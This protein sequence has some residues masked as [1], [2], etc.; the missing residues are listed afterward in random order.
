MPDIDVDQV[1]AK[2]RPFWDAAVG[3]DLKLKI[4][5]VLY[6][7][8]QPDSA[9]LTL[10]TTGNPAEQQAALA[11]LFPNPGPQLTDPLKVTAIVT[12]IFTAFGEAAKKK[13]QASRETMA[14]AVMAQLHPRSATSP[15]PSS[16]T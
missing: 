10:L 14:E 12:S 4:D 7:V 9:D 5:G 2:T 16:Q 13:S 11:S 15:G 6:V 3:W 1:V 8:R